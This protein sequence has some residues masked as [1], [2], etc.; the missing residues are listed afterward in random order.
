ME[1]KY[2]EDVDDKMRE[3]QQPS[4]PLKWPFSL[5]FLN[6]PTLSNVARFPWLLVPHFLS[7]TLLSLQHILLAFAQ[8][9]SYN[10]LLCY[11]FLIS[12]NFDFF[13]S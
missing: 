5:D 2:E 9:M 10:I 7:D 4:G 3:L 12:L 13:L 8:T 1:E 11:Y 6:F